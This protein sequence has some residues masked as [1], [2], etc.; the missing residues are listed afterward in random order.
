MPRVPWWA[1]LSA[2]AVF[3]GCGAFF[4]SQPLGAANAYAGIASFFVALLTGAAALFSLAR[5]RREKEAAKQHEGSPPPGRR[6]T[7]IAWKNT[8]VNQGDI[9]HVD[10]WAP[11]NQDKKS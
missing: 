6:S 2:C 3:I 9:E 5:S 7:M 1:V 4:A 11:P 8:F 10:I